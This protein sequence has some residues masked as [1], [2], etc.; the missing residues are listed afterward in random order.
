MI[1]VSQPEF[2]LSFLL[3]HPP[4]PTE[5]CT[6]ICM[7]VDPQNPY[8]SR[9]LSTMTKSWSTRRMPQGFISTTTNNWPVGTCR[10]GSRGEQYYPSPRSDKNMKKKK[11]HE[12]SS[13]KK[14]NGAHKQAR[15]PPPQEILSFW[16]LIFQ[17]FSRFDSLAGPFPCFL[18]H[19]GEFL[20]NLTLK[21][22]NVTNLT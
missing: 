5:M 1:R 14:K 21:S 6:I 12:S 13:D 8:F 16:A 4:L 2:A 9:W 3:F 7:R 19:F 20:P 17:N 22:E 18:P 10:R 11:I 15:T